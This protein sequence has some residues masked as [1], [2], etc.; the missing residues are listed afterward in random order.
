MKNVKYKVGKK[1]DISCLPYES[2]IINAKVVFSNGH[3]GLIY[4]PRRIKYESDGEIE[5]D[6]GG[7]GSL[8]FAVFNDIDKWWERCTEDYINITL[9]KYETRKVHISCR[10]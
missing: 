7:V 5:N 6:D 3:E 1:E 9:K 8:S 2:V 4:I 10:S